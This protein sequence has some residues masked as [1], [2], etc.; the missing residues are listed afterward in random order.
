MP[1]SKADL[2]FRS[3]SYP[4]SACS[5]QPAKLR[6][7]FLAFSRSG[8]SMSVSTTLPGVISHERI[9]C[10]FSTAKTCHF[11][12]DF[13]RATIS[14]P[15][16]LSSFALSSYL[17]VSAPVLSAAV[18]ASLASPTPA[19]FRHALAVSATMSSSHRMS[20]SA[21]ALRIVVLSGTSPSRSRSQDAAAFSAS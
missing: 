4:L 11:R 19:F 17:S 9:T 21:Y 15:V 5:H 14:L 13:A 3:E 6:P 8:D 18:S 2:Q 10:S 12:Y 16:S 1:I 20:R 7:G